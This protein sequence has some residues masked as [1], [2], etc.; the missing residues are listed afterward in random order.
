MKNRKSALV[1]LVSAVALTGCSSSKD[2]SKSNFEK[3]I[4]GY[5]DRHCVMLSTRNSNFPVTIE[6]LPSDNKWASKNNPE[7][8]KQYD[9]LAK[10]GLLDVKDGETKSTSYTISL[11][12][13]L[14]P[15]KIYSLTEKGKQ[16]FVKSEGK[17]LTGWS[18]QGFCVAKLKVDEI[19]GFSDPAQ[20]MGYTVSNVNFSFSPTGVKDWAKNQ[21]VTKAFPSLTGDL[22]EN[23]QDSIALVLMNDGWVHERDMKR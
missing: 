8:T 16:N 17:G 1:F 7:K 9:A 14:V 20:M 19:T 21:E 3:V 11:K 15:A 22:E 6:L 23:Q 12:N 4:N 10:V 18:N 2:A 5:F 13:T